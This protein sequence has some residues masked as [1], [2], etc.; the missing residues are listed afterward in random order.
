[1]A[2]IVMAPRKVPERSIFLAGSIDMGAAVNWQER[3]CNE[4]KDVDGL[5]IF[6]PRRDDWDSSWRQSI[7]D[8]KF[9]EQVNWEMDRLEQADFVCFYFDP[10]GQAPITLLELGYMLGKKEPKQLVVCCPEGFW[11]KGN[12]EVMCHRH[13]VRLVDNIQAMLDVIRWRLADAK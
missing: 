7:L 13:D 10:K 9:N 6:N 4:F 5:T 12:V 8:P 11:R 1:M 2:K 3:V